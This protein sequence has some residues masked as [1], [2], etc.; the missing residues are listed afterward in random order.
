MPQKIH[1]GGN[2]VTITEY[3]ISEIDEFGDIQDV[4]HAETEERAIEKAHAASDWDAVVVEKVV[5]RHPAREFDRPVSFTTIYT[6]GNRDALIAGGWIEEKNPA[7]VELGKL[8][9]K[10]TSDA[11]RQASAANGKKGGRPRKQTE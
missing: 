7:A 8:G 9:G 3:S 6:A 2:R 1:K 5:R 11:K 4:D 10:S